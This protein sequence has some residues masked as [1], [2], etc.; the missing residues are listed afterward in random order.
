MTR[1]AE[2]QAGRCGKSLK[3]ENSQDWKSRLFNSLTIPTLILK[4]NKVI[5]DANASFLQRFGADKQEVAG[6]TCHDFFYN[7]ADKCPLESCVLN[8]VLADRRGHAVLKYVTTSAGVEKWDNR[9]F[10]PIL[11]EAG[12]VLYVVECIHDVT[13]LKL[14]ERELLG[15]KDFTQKLIERSTTAIIAADRQGKILTMNPAAE[16]LTGYSLQEA[17]TKITAKQ[18][19]P[20]GQGRIIMNILRDGSRGGKGKLH[21]SRFTL[22][23][24]QGEEI[25][26]ELTAAI[27]YE[28]GQ[29]AATVG[30]FNDL[31]EKLKHEQAMQEMLR[32]IARAEKM[33]SLGQLAAGVAHEINNPLTGIIFYADL[34]RNTLAEDDPRRQNLTC[35]YEDARRCGKIIKNLLA[36]S[37][38]E[39]HREEI[40]HVNTLLEL[41]LDLIRDPKVFTG[42]QI[43]K[44]LSE[45]IMLVKGDIDQLG[46]V[47]VNLVLN[48]VDAMDNKGT[49]TLRAYPNKPEQKACIE[50]A[51]TGRGIPEKDLPL[52]FDPFFTTKPTGKGTGLG[53]STAYGI[54]KEN[55]GRIWVKETSQKGTTFAVEL[56]LYQP[57]GRGKNPTNS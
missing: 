2:F 55:Q 34:L 19:Y 23:N 45:D 16:E 41:S 24:A 40:L 56:P 4:P 42:V 29:E 3:M 28:G 48:A 36:Y 46:Q 35:V 31:R 38:Q 7:S 47:I 8:E 14:L 30:L 15:A 6:K 53:L 22:I 50:V 20:P 32:R 49:I 13:Q 52:I 9:V 27:I 33:A 21:L 43:K 39:T 25:P 37:R 5:V 18:L 10:S 26:V 1:R 12:E 51:D 17:Q 57:S 54:I 44:E 11:D